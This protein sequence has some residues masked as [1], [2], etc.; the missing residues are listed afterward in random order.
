[1]NRDHI[2]CLLLVI[3][4]VAFTILFSA[5][6]YVKY[7]SFS[8]HDIDLALLNQATWNTARGNLVSH[9]PGE[10]TIFNGGHVFLVLFIIVPLYAFFSSPMTLL[11]LQSMAL[12]LGAWPVYL[13]ARD[14][15]K[16]SGGLIFA[17]CY[18]IYPALNYVSLFEFHPVAFS[19][20]LLLFMFLFYIRRKWGLFLLFMVL[21][22]SCREDVA[23]PV[24]A[25]G[26][27]CLIQACCKPRGLRAVQLKWGLVPLLSGIIWFIVC[28]KFIQPRFSLP[29]IMT[30]TGG[31]VMLG[32]YSWLGNSPGE[33]CHTLVFHPGKVLRGVLIAPK[34]VYFKDLFLPLAFVS[35]FSPSGL[36]MALISLSEGL[37]SQRF[38]HYSIRYQ[39][40]SIITPFV[41]ISAVYGV[42]NILRWKPMEGKEKY[43]FAV[44]LLFSILSAMTLGPLLKLPEGLKLWRVTYE[45]KIRARLVDGI[46]PRAP[47][48]ATFEFTPKLSMRP[49]L[50]YFYH[51]YAVSRHPDFGVN[52]SAAQEASRYALIDFNDPLTFYDFYTPGGDRDVYAFLS[53]GGWELVETINSMALFKKGREAELGLIGKG[54]S[55]KIEHPLNVTLLPQLKL[56]GYSLIP[57]EVLGAKVVEMAVYFR[58]LDRIPADFLPG[59]RFTSRKDPAFS[60]KQEFFAPYRIYPSS[61]WRPGETVKQKCN[62]LIPEG[63]PSGA[64]DL[65]LALLAQKGTGFEGSVIYRAAGALFLP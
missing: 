2:F 31:S 52:V 63:A 23:I 26:I 8:F 18:L 13:M 19:T 65:T 47:V 43:I 48:I 55:G 4:I 41:F 59:A 22:L 6:A 17:F 51:V 46:P 21:S 20:P 35:I 14:L 33:I 30:A 42:R 54:D 62:I 56:S 12:A 61:R 16:P 39:Y 25:V 1:M 3:F 5:V 7:Q 45:D 60:F 57:A 58:C 29:Q 15:L 49:R 53:G 36:L 34:L 24:I 50:F 11:F 32:F 37:L 64:Y 40:T 9:S 38:T 44:I 28:I 10:A 27:F